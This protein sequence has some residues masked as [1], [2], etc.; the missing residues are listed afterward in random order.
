MADGKVALPL[1]IARIGGG[2][3]LPNGEAVAIDVERLLG[4]ALRHEHVANSLVGCRQ[5]AQPLRIAGIAGSEPFEDSE[6]VAIG[7]DSLL[8][9]SLRVQDVGYP[10]VGGG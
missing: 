5:T 7:L 6:G 8:K 1:R 2:Q 9:P 3:A 10:A 4:L